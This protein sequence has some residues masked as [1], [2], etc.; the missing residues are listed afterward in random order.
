MSAGTPSHNP[1]KHQ[2]DLQLQEILKFTQQQTL[3]SSQLID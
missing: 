3:N 2:K 1:G